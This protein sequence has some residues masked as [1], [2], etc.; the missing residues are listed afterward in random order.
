MRNIMK[1]LL[2]IFVGFF[3]IVPFF[4]SASEDFTQEF[5]ISSKGEIHLVGKMTTRQTL[6]S[7]TVTVW[8]QKWRIQT[9]T[10]VEYGFDT[11][12][13]S[14]YGA[15][16]QLTDINESDILEVFGIPDSEHPNVIQPRIIKNLSNKS[17]TPPIPVSAPTQKPEVTPV[18]KQEIEV[19][20][21]DIPTDR[22]S[23]LLK[24]G[25][26]GPD[27]SLLQAFLEKYATGVPPDGLITGYFGKQTESVLKNFQEAH[28]LAAVGTAG[29]LTRKFI[30][31]ILFNE[32]KP[33]DNTASSSSTSKT[34]LM[35]QSSAAT[36][37]SSPTVPKKKRTLFL[38]Y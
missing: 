6:N 2:S 21:E 38:G 20:K 7:F 10:V 14:A 12:L 1:L 22:L 16:I 17:G 34:P 31:S 28:A 5:S 3:S 11:K 26:R 13:Q 27:V 9:G 29:P 24:L 23:R 33:K 37:T 15:D 32:I 35:F 36:S 18:K 4:A 8:G 30:N 25:M 19:K